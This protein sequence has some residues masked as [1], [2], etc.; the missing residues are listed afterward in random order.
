MIP[1]ALIV[2]QSPT[3][4][5]KLMA[6]ALK[7]A[8]T[9][10]SAD[11]VIHLESA[12]HNR[13]SKTQYAVSLFPPAGLALQIEEPTQNGVAAS[14][15]R[16][17]LKGGDF[18]AYDFNSKES[19]HR[20]IDARGTIADRLASAIGPY[21]DS[22][23]M[24][25]DPARMAS[26]F[27]DLGR[28]R[29]WKV[30]TQRRTKTL[31]R[32]AAGSFMVLA[33]DAQ[34]RQLVQV[35]FGSSTDSVA[36][37]YAYTKTG[38]ALN[39]ATPPGTREVAAFFSAP[40]LPRFK[41]KDAETALV[42]SMQAYRRLKAGRVVIEEGGRETT[43]TFGGN[44]YMQ[45][46]PGFSWAYEGKSLTIFDARKNVVMRGPSSR[47]RVLTTVAAAGGVVDP[48]AKMLLAQA[49][50]FADLFTP[51]MTVSTGGSIEMGPK[52]YLVLRAEQ[53]RL[54]MSMLV[55]KDTQLIESVTSD[56]VDDRGT[57][58][59]TT[60]R[61]FRYESIGETPKS[62]AIPIPANAKALALPT[63]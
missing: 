40:S 23:K 28:N 12:S 15:R 3:V 43:I 45:V 59:S 39:F 47:N 30:T 26:F 33:F 51:T 2:A 20:K 42:A 57:V 34:T 58:I 14:K 21:D 6:D 60:T 9:A 44:R 54:R 35:Q 32:R 24:I 5:Q 11:V 29:D 4:A 56:V 48:F 53:P 8:R 41:S 55:R 62:V 19:I 31:S 25:V 13:R 10:K 1:F 18:L 37:R 22:L 16:Y 52:K 36:C 50:P 17:I 46:G 63:L 7:V 61:R 38:L 27:A 49:P